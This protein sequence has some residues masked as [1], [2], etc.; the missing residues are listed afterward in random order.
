MSAAG[1]ATGSR[2]LCQECGD[3][4]DLDAPDVVKAMPSLCIDT[5]ALSGGM[6]GWIEGVGVYFHG[7]CFGFAGDG[8]TRFDS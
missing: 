3:P 2:P 7:D 6:S 4:V 8:F 5:T 1:S